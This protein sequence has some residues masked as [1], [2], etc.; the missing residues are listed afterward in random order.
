MNRD[1]MLKRF[2]A[3]HCSKPGESDGSTTSLIR[4]HCTPLLV[5]ALANIKWGG[6]R[7]PA[8]PGLVLHHLPAGAEPLHANLLGHT[9]WPLHMWAVLAYQNKY[10]LLLMRTSR[11]RG[12]P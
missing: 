2:G 1:D 8:T 6:S 5:R 7:A 11:T 12:G 10:T 4:L 3:T 9:S